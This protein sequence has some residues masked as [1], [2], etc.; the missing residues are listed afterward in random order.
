MTLNFKPLAL[1][2]SVSNK[3]LSLAFIIFIFIFQAPVFAG[4]H[5]ITV[6][7]PAPRIVEPRA[8]TTLVFKITNAGTSKDTFLLSTHLPEGWSTISSLGPITLKPGQYKKKLL[9]IS[10]PPTALS[11]ISYPIELTVRS[12]TD[13]ATTATATAQLHVK[14]ILGLRLTPGPYPE[15]VWSGE[16]VNYD[17]EIKNLG[18]SNDIFEIKAES[19][20]KWKFEISKKTVESTF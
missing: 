17:F 13:A 7:P 1:V 5:G 2:R 8:F 14:N 11:T 4:P 12:K 6:A 15:L 10:V 18:N 3:Y 19:S 16:T 20:R 9:T